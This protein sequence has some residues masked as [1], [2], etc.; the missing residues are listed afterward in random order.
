[1][2]TQETKAKIDS[3]TYAEMLRQWRFAPSGNPMFQG[4]VGNYFFQSMREKKK[5]VDF[6]AIS[7]NI[8]W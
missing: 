5:N 1:M 3:M 2:L 6:V 4:E 7:K 8:G